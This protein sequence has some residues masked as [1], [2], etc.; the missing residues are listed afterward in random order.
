MFVRLALCGV[1][2]AAGLAVTASAQTVNAQ[3][4]RQFAVCEE[5]QVRGRWF[6]TFGEGRCPPGS[7]RAA[8]SSS[9][10]NDV[11]ARNQRRV[12]SSVQ[13][14]QNAQQG[15]LS[16]GRAIGDRMLAASERKRNSFSYHLVADSENPPAQGLYKRQEQVFP[17]AGTIVH[18]RAGEPIMV[19][20]EAFYSDCFISLEGGSARQIGGHRHTVQDGELVCKLQ[21]RDRAYTPLYLNY[22]FSGGESS[23][24]QD[25]EQKGDTYRICYRNMGTNAMCIKDIPLDRVIKNIGIV[26]DRTTARELARLDG[27]RNGVL[28]IRMGEGRSEQTLHRF[29]IA[30]SRII[31]IDGHEFEVLESDDDEIILRRR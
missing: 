12:E 2:A 4:Y 11:N 15:V 30:E 16:L 21:E 18:A 19:A 1:I 13:A 3:N 6:N 9:G 23:M 7:R 24:G 14:L 26:E 31:S 25:L 17:L 5:V 27:V 28:S 10:Q 22:S 20:S 29:N 8:S